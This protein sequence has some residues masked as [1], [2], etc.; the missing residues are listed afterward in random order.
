MAKKVQIHGTSK[1]R[2]LRG[3]KVLLS[4]AERKE[5]NHGRSEGPVFGRGDEGLTGN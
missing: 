1:K 4:G 3:K 5:S 2:P